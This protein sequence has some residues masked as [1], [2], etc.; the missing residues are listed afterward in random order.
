MGAFTATSMAVEGSCCAADCPCLS[1]PCRAG[2]PREKASLCSPEE[3]RGGPPATGA[4]AH[5]CDLR[6]RLLLPAS[7]GPISCP[8]DPNP[9][10]GPK[11][12]CRAVVGPPRAALHPKTLGVEAGTGSPLLLQPPPA[13]AP[14]RPSSPSLLQSISQSR[15]WRGF[16]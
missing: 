15:F 14:S 4:T 5:R 2:V 16:C 1:F 3:P 7:P 9:S 10:W 12:S 13:P 11:C 6:D 8:V